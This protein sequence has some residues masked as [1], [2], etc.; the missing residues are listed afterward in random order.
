MHSLF[1]VC[2]FLVQQLGSAIQVTVPARTYQ[3]ALRHVPIPPSPLVTELD[4]HY[5]MSN[6]T[7]ESNFQTALVLID[8]WDDHTLVNLYENQNLRVLPLLA[9]AR[10]QGWLIIHA[11]SEGQET[12]MISVLPG[13][14]LV[15]G[16]DQRPG[17]KSLC[18]PYL[19]THNVT[20][21]LFAGYD[22]NYCVLDKPCGTIS[23]SKAIHQQGVPT[24]VVLVRDATLVQSQWYENNYYSHKLSIN[25]IEATPWVPANA[26]AS[27][28]SV[29][30]GDL[31]KAYNVPTDTL[32]YKNATTAL[33]YPMVQANTNDSKPRA[34]VPITAMQRGTAAVVVVSCSNDERDM[35]ANDGYK[36]RMMENRVLHLEPFLA[37]V[38]QNKHR[39]NL[40][41]IH[42]PNGHTIQTPGNNACAPMKDEYVAASTVEFDQY[43]QQENITTLMYV[44]YAAN[45]DMLFGVGGMQRYYTNNRYKHMTVP[46]YYWV[47]EAT[48]GFE[49][50]TSLAGGEWARKQALAYRQPLVT[51]KGNILAMADVLAIVGGNRNLG[52]LPATEIDALLDIYHVNGGEH[53]KYNKGTDAVG[54]GNPWN[55]ANRTLVDPCGEG[56][57]GIECKSG[58][59]SG[60][61]V[62][63]VEKLFINTRHSGNPMMGQ[64]SPLIGQLTQLEHFYSS[65]DQ[66]PSSLIGGIPDTFGNLIHLKCMYFSHNNLT[67]PFPAS[68]SNLTQL[69]VFLARSN[70]ISGQ[71]PNFELMPQLRNVWFDGNK[72]LTGSLVGLGQ[73]KNLTFLKG[74]NNA[75][76]GEVPV[77]LCNIKCDLS[78]NDFKCPLVEKGCCQ[79][80]ACGDA[81]GAPVNP[82][83]TSM[84]ECFPQ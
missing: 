41:I 74:D 68:L 28:R 40:K 64:L 44:G 6:V 32:L 52:Q 57:F 33:K 51:P 48:L 66:T 34:D 76:T 4:N 7:L 19:L 15:T 38:R 5:L 56:W 39:V 53:W 2:T 58:G 72:Q 73:L 55:V 26:S 61:S 80:T 18:F 27:I 75:L 29:T 50:A 36:A 79:V 21:V 30:L 47:E 49:T 24:N 23:I 46:H 14:I 16:E 13:E 35:Y 83:K 77:S 84:G 59:G 20:N 69:Q 3:P 65:N 10:K 31:V 60:G 63:H 37:A 71:L 11:P 22:T 42:V 45:R 62:A 25:M 17:S 67:E 78:Q 54:G 82:P 43:V 8:V 70:H 12:P 1:L 9:L 81:P